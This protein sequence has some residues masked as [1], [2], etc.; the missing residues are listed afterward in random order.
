VNAD[1]NRSQE[2]HRAASGVRWA[3]R[4]L[5]PSLPV[6]IVG[7]IGG[8][9]SC[10]AFH[11]VWRFEQGISQKDLAAVTESHVLALQYGLNEYL[12]KL[13]ALRAFFESSQQVTR[14]EF[15]SF[16]DRLLANEGAIQNFSW[17]ARV[18]RAGRAE[19]ERQARRDGLSDYHIKAVTAD[20]RIVISTEQD[21]Y[22]PVYY[23]TVKLKSS[24]IYGIDLCSEPAI[25]RLLDRA[26]DNDEISA[27]PDFI[28]HSVAGNVHG[29]LFSLPVYRPGVFHETV[30]DRRRN[31]IGFV[32]GA[33]L[34]GLAV[35]HILAATTAERGLDLSLFAADAGPDDPPLYVHSSLLRKVPAVPRT[36]AQLDSGLH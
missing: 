11:F 14:A 20:E 3:S 23:S 25:R 8:I 4:W 18:T 29:F 28:L 33:F 1:S 17:V 9:L 34:T 27:M 32:H 7:L 5:L 13:I 10:T 22:L 12:N 30:E 36:R 24:P 2:A 15:E 35:E 21:E 6:A 19:I 26:R 16:A 31:L